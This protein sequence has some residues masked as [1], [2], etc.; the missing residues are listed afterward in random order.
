MSTSLKFK[1]SHASLEQV[2]GSFGPYAEINA[3]VSWIFAR[4]VAVVKSVPPLEH[5]THLM[6]MD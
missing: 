1:D 4:L 6:L 2:T 5:P 3:F